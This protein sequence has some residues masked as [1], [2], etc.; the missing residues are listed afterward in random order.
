[1]NVEISYS[2]LVGYLNIKRLPFVSVAHAIL[3]IAEVKDVPWRLPPLSPPLRVDNRSS[4]FMSVLTE[5]RM[6]VDLPVI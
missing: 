2:I 1:M 6:S 4:D 5:Y 3:A